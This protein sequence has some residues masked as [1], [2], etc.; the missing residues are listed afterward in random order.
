[1]RSRMS[2]IVLLFFICYHFQADLLEQQ[3]STPCVSDAELD[4]FVREHKFFA[5]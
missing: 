4:A 2:N 3:Q 1:M 5:Q